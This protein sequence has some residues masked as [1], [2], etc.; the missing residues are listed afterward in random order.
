MRWLDTAR[1]IFGNTHGLALPD[2]DRIDVGSVPDTA[3]LLRAIAA[4]MPRTAIVQ[5]IGPRHPPILDF[6]ATRAVARRQST[7]E[8]FLSLEDSSVTD[9][10]RLAGRAPPAEVCAHLFVQEGDDTLLE[11]FGRDRGEDVVWVSQQLPRK[12]LR[13]FVEVASK[14]ASSLGT[15]RASTRPS[16]I[17]SAQG[18]DEQSSTFRPFPEGV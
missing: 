18:R 15:R 11:A 6:L 1:S 2:P 13:L 16:P 14:P 12:A 9:L 3:A 4:A 7:G 5:L 8:Y 10:A 17:A